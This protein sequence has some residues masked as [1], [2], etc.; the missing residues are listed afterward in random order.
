MKDEYAI[1]VD[2]L[3]HGHATGK[4]QPLAQAIGTEHFNLLEVAIRD[5]YRPQLAEQLY[6]GDGPREAVKFIKKKINYNELT[7]NAKAELE[8]VLQDI[9]GNN[10]K[11]FVTFFN[12]AY[13]INARMHSLE[14]IPGIGKKHMWEII[15]AREESEFEDFA[16]IKNRVSSLSNLE[17]M[18]VKR[19]VEELTG[20]EKRYL[21]VAPPKKQG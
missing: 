6:I 9:V 4:P 7:G 14:L 13:P 2:F 16:D 15:D 20:E 19:I 1:V 18:I 3:E 17:N 11:Q 12:E 8:Y 10:E 5:G 21:F